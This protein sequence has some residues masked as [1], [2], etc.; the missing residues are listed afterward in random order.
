[1]EEDL[2]EGDIPHHSNSLVPGERIMTWQSL[3]RMRDCFPGT[4]GAECLV[5]MRFCESVL[6]GIVSDS[7]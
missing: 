2:G 1:M 6:Y 4:H 3:R 5:T 7:N